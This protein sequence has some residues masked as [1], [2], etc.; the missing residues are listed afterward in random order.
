MSGVVHSLVLAT[1]AC[2]K[3]SRAARFIPHCYI[4]N[5]VGLLKIVSIAIVCILQPINNVRVQYNTIVPNQSEAA[6]LAIAI[7]LDSVAMDF[8]FVINL[9]AI[10]IAK[11]LVIT[12]TV[13]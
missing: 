2:K 13:L 7:C 4:I 12:S 5:F 8:N 11:P 6:Q 3:S 1:R 9:V 10:A